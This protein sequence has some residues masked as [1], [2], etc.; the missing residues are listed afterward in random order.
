MPIE[1]LKT[2]DIL[3]LGDGVF[4]CLRPGIEHPRNRRKVVVELRLSCAREL[5]ASEP[6]RKPFADREHDVVYRRVVDSR[7]D[8]KIWML[9]S[10]KTLRIVLVT[11]TSA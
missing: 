2:A 6:A 8:S 9:S 3:E 4:R 11:V 10:P 7:N 1:Y 5:Q